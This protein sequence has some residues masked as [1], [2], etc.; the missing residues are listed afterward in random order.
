[1]DLN[2]YTELKGTIRIAGGTQPKNAGLC[3]FHYLQHG[4]SPIDFMCIGANANQQATKAM[5]V[6]RHIVENSEDFKTVEV[7]FQP[8]L[9]KTPTKD[10][11]TGV[12]QDKNVTV[13]RTV[14]FNRKKI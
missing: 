8:M 5:G 9:F 12:M 6:F 7:A 13:W 1:M 10:N 4:L 2:Y 14:L 3:A 11:A